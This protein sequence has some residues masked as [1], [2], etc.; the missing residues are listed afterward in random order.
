ML[1]GIR[2]TPAGYA[3]V[4]VGQK[5]RNAPRLTHD[6]AEPRFQALIRTRTGEMSAVTLAPAG[7]SSLLTHSLDLR[8]PQFNP[9]RQDQ[10]GDADDERR[11]LGNALLGDCRAVFF[12]GR[13]VHVAKP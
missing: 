12:D 7:A 8:P 1:A 10:R 2:T 5:R 3:S 13:D 11:R 9:C 6:H 4:I